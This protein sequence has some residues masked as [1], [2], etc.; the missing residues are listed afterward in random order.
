M[1]HD[2]YTLLLIKDMLQKLLCC[3]IF[4]GIDLIH[5]YHQM[6]PIEEFLACTAMSPAAGCCQWRL[7]PK[8]VT[9]ANVPFQQMLENL[10]E[11]VPDCTRTFVGGVTIASEDRSMSSDEPQEAHERDITIMLDLL[12][13]HN[14]KG[15]SDKAT[16]A[17]NEVA[18]GGHV[19]GN[20]QRKYIPGNLGD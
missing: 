2:S 4:K 17:V 11:P 5:S 6:P 3:T 9:D 20:G 10:L 18:F 1:Q 8:G 12:L 19:V 7:M 15:S 16:I 13:R 14:L